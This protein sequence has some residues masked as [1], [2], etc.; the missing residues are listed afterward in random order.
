MHQSITLS[1]S[2][3]GHLIYANQGD[4]IQ[5]MAKKSQNPKA[6][7]SLVNGVKVKKF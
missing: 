4:A 5:R 6:S 3:N 2:V 1:M 7:A